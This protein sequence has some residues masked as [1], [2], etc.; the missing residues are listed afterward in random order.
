MNA[1]LLSSRRGWFSAAAALVA[2]TALPG[3][4]FE[5]R[6]APVFAFKSLAVKGNSATVNLIRRNLKAAG[7]VTLVEPGA[8]AEPIGELKA[9]AV[10]EVLAEER[11]RLVVSTNSV[12]LVRDVELL[13]RFRF[14]L[15]TPEGK[16]LLGATT[17]EQR[18]DLTYNETNALAKEA[19]AELLYRDMQS[20]VAQQV[21]RRLGAVKQL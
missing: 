9:D 1:P 16:E 14:K 13:F 15:T 6:K 10:F 12:G 18:R 2:A 8:A 19:E 20:D 17:I 3:C 5:L 7:T 11:S 4:G 21:M